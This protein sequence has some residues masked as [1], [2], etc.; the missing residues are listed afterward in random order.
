MFLKKKHI[1]VVAFS[2][3]IIAIVFIVTLAGYHLY[4][5]WKQ[6]TLALKYRN[7]IYK[8]TAELFRNDVILSNIDLRVIKK[9][10]T[11]ALPLLQGSLKNNSGKKITSISV[12][13]SLEN[14]DGTVVYK[15]WVH[16][17][18]NRSS[19]FGI[20]EYTEKVLLPGEKMSFRHFM[21]NCPYDVTEKISA[22]T[23]FAKE[24]S[25]EALTV[26]FSIVGLTVL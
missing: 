7:S 14:P 6:D 18:G 21:K 15:E 16:P 20:M 24:G 10:G 5:Q 19:S 11:S 13:I 9:E 3:A 23:E 4:I 12:E 8:L 22:K 25:R 1:S 17:L 26:D 2:S